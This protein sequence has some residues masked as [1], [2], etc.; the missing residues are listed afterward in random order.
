[1]IWSFMEESSA[2]RL[3]LRAP[4]FYA[5]I[6]ARFAELKNTLEKTHGVSGEEL[7]FCFALDPKQGH[8]IEPDREKLLQGDCLD[9]VIFAGRAEPGDSPAS[10]GT[11]TLPAGMYLFSQR[12]EALNKDEWL[13]MAIEQQKDGLWER[14]KLENRLFVRYL[15]EDNSPVTQ[16]FRPFGL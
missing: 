14:L 11:V 6:P 5:E 4:L 13:S 10:E 15:F 3:D 7:I 16:V 12:R 8:S 2:V 9:A 1:M